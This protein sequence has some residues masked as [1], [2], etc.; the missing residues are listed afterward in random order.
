MK[1]SKKWQLLYLRAMIDGELMRNDWFRNEKTLGY[2]EKIVEM[3][4][5]QHAGWA[6]KPDVVIVD[7]EQSCHKFN[8]DAGLV[9]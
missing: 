8:V 1:N 2:F 5:L 4:H 6:T 7:N 3:C 9:R